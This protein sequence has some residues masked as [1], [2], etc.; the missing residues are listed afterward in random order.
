MPTRWL[1]VAIVA[2]WL[3][4][5]AWLFWRD[6]WPN[7]R[8]G[9]P[10]PYNVDLV[11][12]AQHGKAQVF[13]SV[14]QNGQDMFSAKTWVEHHAD[15]DTF[16]LR[17]EFLAKFAQKGQPVHGMLKVL[18]MKSACHVSREGN[19][20]SLKAEFTARLT[21][22]LPY[23]PAEMQMINATFAGEVHHGQFLPHYDLTSPLVPGYSYKGRLAAVDVSHR[24]AVLLPLHPV[25]R[26]V[27]LRP[28][29]TWRVPEVNLFAVGAAAFFGD[30]VRYLHA[31]V[32][33]QT[34]PVLYRNRHVPC[35]VVEYTGEDVT[36]R[37]YVD[38]KTGLVLQQEYRQDNDQW[39]LLRDS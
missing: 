22:H 6:L 23:L 26:I 15:D 18:D 33:D 11:E 25:N 5:S 20:L 32:L 16:T 27:G 21:R 7:W 29:Q 13:W 2:F 38:E 14:R 28:G 36:A 4:T 37:T 39:V 3:G 8:P 19:L 34:E 9:E 30:N 17:E 1:C 35:L 31:R 12:E 10:P 24:G